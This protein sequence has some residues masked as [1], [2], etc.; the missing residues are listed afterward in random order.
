MDTVRA[1]ATA[2]DEADAVMGRLLVERQAL[3]QALALKRD[4]LLYAYLE[5]Y[6]A[7]HPEACPRIEPAS[8][9]PPPDTETETSL[10]ICQPCQEAGRFNS[11]A[12]V[13]GLPAEAATVLLDAARKWHERCHGYGCTCQHK[14]GDHVARATAPPPEPEPAPAPEPPHTLEWT[15]HAEDHASDALAQA[16]DAL[17]RAATGEHAPAHD[18]WHPHP[19]PLVVDYEAAA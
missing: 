15:L 17:A 19:P 18:R 5:A 3:A 2:L 12:L 14:V 8:T 10:V 6:D 1:W 4:T 16:A 7:E 13:E 11:A 9:A